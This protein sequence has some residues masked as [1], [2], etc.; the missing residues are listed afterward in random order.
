MLVGQAVV[1]IRREDP[2]RIVQ[3]A[4]RQ[5]GVLPRARARDR[6]GGARARG[7]RASTPLIGAGVYY[8]AAMTEAAIYRGQ[9]V[10]VVGGANSAGQGALFFSRYARHGH[11]A[12]ARGQV[13]EP[14]DVAVSRR[15]HRRDGE[16]RGGDARRGRRPCAATAT[17]S[18]VALRHV[19]DRRGPRRSTRR[20]MF[21]F[22]GV[23]P[24][25]ETFAGFVQLDDKGFILT[26]PDLR[27]AR[28]WTLDRDPLMFE[29]T[30]RAC[31]PSATCAPGRTAASPPRSA[32]ARRRC[33]RCISICERS[34]WGSEGSRL[35]APK[36]PSSDSEPGSS[37]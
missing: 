7:A 30:C 1:G 36:A 27:G 32:K 10:C 23:A 31:S 13:A 26:G 21:I 34:D 12:G 29:T 5:G 8:G 33:F 19:D 20:R 11:D 37:S 4:E 9:D 25:T 22:I 16:H 3:L 14:V 2:Y 28:G 17:S 15:P 24:R 35:K 18:S 6:H